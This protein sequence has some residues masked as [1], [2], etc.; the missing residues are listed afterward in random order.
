MNL[1]LGIF[2]VL[3]ILAAFA[4]HLAITTTAN[5]AANE[6]DR[7]SL[8]GSWGFYPNNGAEKFDINVPAYWDETMGNGHPEEWATL[9][10]GVY[11]KSFSMPDSMLEKRIFLNI[12]AL[13]VL[14]KVFI[15][16]TRIGGETTGNYLQMMLPYSLDITRH[17][18][19]TGINNL[20]F[21]VYGR[22]R[23]PADA[24]KGEKYIY[25]FGTEMLVG[26]KG[27]CGD[28]S[29][30]AYPK[31]HISD[32][33]VIAD[34]KK[35]TDP[36]DDTISINVTVTN[37]SGSDQE[38]T[39]RNKAALRGGGHDKTFPDKSLRIEEG[40]SRTIS[41]SN[42]SW[43]DAEYWWPHDPKLYILSTSLVQGES[44]MDVV[45]HR[46]GFRQFYA[47]ENNN[48]FELNG[49][50]CNLRGDNIDHLCVNMRWGHANDSSIAYTKKLLDEWKKANL[51]VVRSHCASVFNPEILDHCDEIG[52]LYID[53]PPYWQ[54][55]QQ[56]LDTGSAAELYMHE[57]M[58]QWVKSRKN[59]P[60]LI[61]Y[62]ASNEEEQ[63]PLS[64]FTVRRSAILAYD[65]T[66][67]VYNEGAQK[68]SQHD[69]QINY[70]YTS[71]DGTWSTTDP[72][73]R[74]SLYTLFPN[75]GTTKPR[76]E[77]ECMWACSDGFY[78][79]LDGQGAISG[80]CE[81]D[82]SAPDAPSYAVWAR[83]CARAVRGARYQGIADYRSFLNIYHAFEW[84]EGPIMPE[85]TD[86]SAPGL[87]PVVMINRHYNPYDPAY[88]SVI[89]GDAYDYY[90]NSYAP[91]AAFDLVCDAENMIGAIPSIYAADSVLTRKIVVYNDEFSG[92]HELKV[93]WVACHKEPGGAET[94]IPDAKGSFPITVNY[95][96][97]RTRE[98][99]FTIPRGITGNKI[100]NLKLAV[101][102][103][104]AVRFEETNRLGYINGTPDAK[105]HISNPKIDLGP[106]R[107]QTG[108]LHKIKLINI[109]GGAS[110]TW[111][112]TGHADWLKLNWT[113]GN[114][115]REQEVF[116]TVD[117]E[118]MKA[119]TAY[120]T[121]VMFTGKHGTKASATITIGGK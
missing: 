43:A 111:T 65:K 55:V 112:A 110:E 103:N 97:K 92:G 46:F 29:I 13:T 30:V 22:N 72:I 36:A 121:T 6:R 52:M 80:Q 118:G 39:I 1:N 4:A 5:A 117:T 69:D 85:W 25:P 83:Q 9:G 120:S 34:L 61:M 88:P 33:Q 108:L 38:L 116:Y 10:Y 71:A 19:M 62:A 37:H 53:E 99:I 23:F 82:G 56:G 98:I 47:K 20:E 100:L 95:G 63:T 107:P 74:K 76:G 8:N 15:N 42:F 113:S 49:I 41:I 18:N 64:M 87:K 104:D 67:P 57:Y 73:I 51:N 77:G 70:H 26:R 102:K 58:T 68:F 44:T 3:L 11:R 66:R 28:V 2:H 91:V 115:R 75:A 50:R 12:G 45:N 35:N 40:A 32:V 86:R 101:S 24:M 105:I 96:E 17:A 94:Q 119:G 90:K 60:S 89:Y 14:G 84:I 78:P 106:I 114:L 16:G 93:D 79:K 48:Y 109:G 31:I 54:S 81:L 59:H 7:L 27:I 21:H